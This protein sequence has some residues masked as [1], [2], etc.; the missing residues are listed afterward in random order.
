MVSCR[1]FLL[2]PAVVI[3]RGRGPQ[4]VSF[5]SAGSVFCCGEAFAESLSMGLEASLASHFAEWI[6][7]PSATLAH[8]SQ[9]FEFSAWASS[10]H[11]NLRLQL[12]GNLPRQAVLG[13]QLWH[14]VSTVV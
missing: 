9:H 7:T 12:L 13:T 14:N 3:H 4:R 2:L 1:L 6:S 11:T 8:K 5:L 10:L